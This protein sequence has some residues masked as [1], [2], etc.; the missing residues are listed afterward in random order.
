MYRSSE[1]P[2]TLSKQKHQGGFTINSKVL[3]PHHLL[4]RIDRYPSTEI[5]RR[6]EL[7][8]YFRTLLYCFIEF[9]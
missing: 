5:I 9:K 7:L 4:H 6:Q 2:S 1:F 8:P 3:L